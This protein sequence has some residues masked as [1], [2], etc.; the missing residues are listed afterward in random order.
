[1]EGLKVGDVVK[2]KSGGPHMT[3]VGVISKELLMCNWFDGQTVKAN[4]FPHEALE[5]VSDGQEVER[6]DGG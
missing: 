3:V 5:K 6:P 1:M 2:L 4:H